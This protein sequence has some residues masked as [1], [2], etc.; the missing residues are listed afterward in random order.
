MGRS[1]RKQN[2]DNQKY[3]SLRIQAHQTHQPKI[4]PVPKEPPVSDHLSYEMTKD[5]SPV[6][7][8]N[9]IGQTIYSMQYVG[10]EKF[11]YWVEYDEQRRI[12]GYTN[13][14]GY[15]WKCKYN[16][17]GN[18][19]DFWDNEGYQEKYS[20]YKDGLVIMENSF[21]QKIKKHIARNKVFITRE[22]FL[23][24]V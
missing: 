14:R 9:D 8:M 23:N 17:R 24:A 2:R 15:E 10:D 16:S 11:E 7:K 21:G 1:R 19:S 20:Y 5:R 22:I 6:T 4:A 3:K 13:S 18:I 12:I